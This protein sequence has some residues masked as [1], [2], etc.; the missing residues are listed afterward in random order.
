MKINK[1]FIYAIYLIVLTLFVGRKVHN[2]FLPET[3]T[4]FYYFILRSFHPLFYITYGLYFLQ[5]TFQVIHLVPVALYALRIRWLDVEFWQHLLIL[6][7]ILDLS[8]HN[9]EIKQ[10]IAISYYEPRIAVFVF[11]Q[12]ILIYV[13]SYW[14]CYQ[15]AFKQDRMFQ[16]KPVQ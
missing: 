7:F 5:V 13:P 2:L 4:F 3:A 12:S 10:I 14:L 15:Y 11:L 8:G 6:R 1:R 9:Y 16:I